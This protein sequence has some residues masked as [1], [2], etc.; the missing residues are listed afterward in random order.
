MRFQNKDWHS[1]GHRQSSAIPTL[2]P[3]AEVNRNTAESTGSQ[4]V[5]HDAFDRLLSPKIIHIIIHN[6]NKIIVMKCQ[7]SD[8]MLGGSPQR[9]ELY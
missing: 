5:G 9:E 1:L 7:Q 3:N 8:F 6:H 4:L 2:S